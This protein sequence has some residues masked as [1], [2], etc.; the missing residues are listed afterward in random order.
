VQ[1]DQW[2]AP[3]Q[4]KRKAPLTEKVDVYSLGNVLYFLLTNGTKP[5]HDMDA[6][7]AFRYLGKKGGKLKIK[8]PAILNSTHP[9]HVNVIQAME[10]CHE[11][12]PDKRVDA[13]QV[14]DFLGPK[15]DEYLK[16]QA[17]ERSA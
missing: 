14:R 8:D 4:Y 9:F 2:Q 13:R 15:L 11:H 3:E 16:K 12:D 5:F 7:D 6:G 17:Q 1:L 10:M